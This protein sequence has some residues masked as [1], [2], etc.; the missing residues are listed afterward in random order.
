MKPLVALIISILLLILC[1]C[2]AII[3]NRLQYVESVT[4]YEQ[5]NPYSIPRNN[6]AFTRIVKQTEHIINKPLSS[7][8]CT[9][10]TKEDFIRNTTDGVMI[11]LEKPIKIKIKKEENSEVGEATLNALWISLDPEQ[12]QLATIN[13]VQPSLFGGNKKCFIDIKKT[14][15][16]YLQ[17]ERK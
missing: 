3:S 16:I 13:E 14:A 2:H 6:A 10:L 7:C 17:K 5:G 11:E 4:L 1:G 8:N 12:K 15:S 9:F